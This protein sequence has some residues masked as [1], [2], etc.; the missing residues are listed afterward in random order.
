[1]K[2][3]ELPDDLVLPTVEE[4]VEIDLRPLNSSKFV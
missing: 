3:F 2:Y 1:M 4:I